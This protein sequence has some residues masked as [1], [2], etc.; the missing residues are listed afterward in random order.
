MFFAF[1]EALFGFG[2]ETLQREACFAEGKFELPDQI[3]LGEPALLNV[4]GEGLVTFQLVLLAKALQK[5]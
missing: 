5:L 1:Q 4:V 3:G 2:S